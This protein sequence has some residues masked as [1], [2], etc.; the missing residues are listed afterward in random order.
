VP[1]HP[2]TALLQGYEL[3]DS[4]NTI[5][6]TAAGMH[7]GINEAGTDCIDTDTFAGHFL[8]KSEFRQGGPLLRR[9]HGFR[10]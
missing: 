3:L 2:V 10:Q 8:R 5:R 1:L 6:F 9:F 4:I 7:L